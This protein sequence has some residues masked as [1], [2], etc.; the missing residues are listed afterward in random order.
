MKTRVLWVED[1]ARLELRSLLGPVYMS[2]DYDLSLAEDATDA[3]KRLQTTV[4]DAIILDMRIPPGMD[5]Q[6][7]KIYREREEDKAF[8]RLGLELANWMFNGHSFLYP[9][10]TWVRP[11][12]VGVFTVEDDPALHARL[13]VLKIE[14]FEHKTAGIADTI[15]VKIIER[16]VE[17]SQAAG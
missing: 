3:M 8:A 11:H 13:E 9:P 4:Y 10:P 12:H 6:W 17:K 16:I 2:G 1:S 14:V 7:I 15:L 5:E